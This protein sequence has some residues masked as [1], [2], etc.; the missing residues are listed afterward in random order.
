VTTLGHAGQA[1]RPLT[2]LTGLEEGRVLPGLLEDPVLLDAERAALSADLATSADRVAEALHRILG[3][4]TALGGSVCLSY[5]CRDLREHRE[6]FPSWVVLQALRLAQP[7]GRLTYRDLDTRV[8]EPASAVP[9]TPAEA[10]SDAGWWLAGLRGAP[11]GSPAVVHAA[12]PA[13]ARGAAAEAAR[14]GDAFTE[15]D[16]W[17][18]EAGPVLDPAAAAGGVSATALEGLAGCPFRY[19]LKRGLGVEPRDETAPDPDRWLDPLTLG[20]V[21][22]ELFARFL[23]ELR[24]AGERP[25][26]ARHAARLLALGEERLQALRRLMPPPSELVFEREARAYRRDLETFLRLEAAETGRTSVG[27]EVAFGTGGGDGEPLARAEPVLIDLGPGLR[28]RLRGRIDR[29]DRLATGVYEAVDYKTGGYW[30]DTW[31]GRFA[32]GRVL[33]HAL[34]A[35]AAAE[36]LQAVDP[37]ARVA[38]ASY[39]FP[40]VRG[41]GTRVVRM[42]DDPGGLAALLTDLFAVVRCGAF[43]HTMTDD[44]CRFCE[45]WRACGPGP[46][47]RAARKV[48]ATGNPPLD[49]YRRLSQHA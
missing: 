4:L 23:R 41:R 38:S 7:D 35:R 36:L 43:V 26:P 18:P 11:P 29:I 2:F 12:F 30:A 1:G 6:T 32:G 49:A 22:H 25:E 40:T 24:A 5:S 28:F 9:A 45:H 44:D 10:L 27:F 34:Y 37:G 17:V 33:Q 47:A 15:Y 20:Q 46:A 42:Q 8:G 21:F 3:R 14:E 39:Y 31:A 19:W 16:G 13:L 48:V